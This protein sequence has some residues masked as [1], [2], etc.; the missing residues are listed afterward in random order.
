ME[1]DTLCIRTK[2]IKM[3]F[4]QSEYAVQILT[5]DCAPGRFR[6]P[7][8]IVDF[9]YYENDEQSIALFINPDFKI[10]YEQLSDFAGDGIFTLTLKNNLEGRC[11]VHRIQQYGL[12]YRIEEFCEI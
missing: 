7:K 11:L 9:L 5:P 12:G 8:D 4:F 1:S 6:I 2:S 10:E 3:W